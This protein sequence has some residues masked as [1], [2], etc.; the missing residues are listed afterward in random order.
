MARPKPKPYAPVSLELLDAITLAR[1]PATQARIV[2]SVARRTVGDYGKPCAPISESLLEHMTGRSPR[3]IQ[4][5]LQDLVKHGVIEVRRK[6]RG[7]RPAELRM[8]ED[9]ETW[10][11]YSDSHARVT[12]RDRNPSENPDEAHARDALY[13]N[14]CAS[15]NY[16]IARRTIQLPPGHRKQASP[17]DPQGI[18]L[19]SAPSG[20]HHSETLLEPR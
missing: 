20:I 17:S 5:A 9:Y 16:A 7:C 2:W 13:T 3:G 6:A 11:T 12:R 4:K 19:V 8:N 15:E 18:R 1:F 14:S 10:G